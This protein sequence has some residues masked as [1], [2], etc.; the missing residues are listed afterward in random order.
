M[1]FSLLLTLFVAPQAAPSQTSAVDYFPADTLVVADFSLEPWDRLRQNTVAHPLLKELRI[2]RTFSD[3]LQLEIEGD[4]AFDDKY[5]LRKVLAESRFYLGLPAT[6]LPAG[7]LL[8]GVDALKVS[9]NGDIGVVFDRFGVQYK[10]VGTSLLAILA[11][12][13]SSKMDDEDAQLILQQYIDAAQP[14]E[15]SIPYTLSNQKSWKKLQAKAGGNNRV[16]GL[17]IPTEPWRDGHWRKLAERFAGD[18]PEFDMVMQIFGKIMTSMG[19][20]KIEGYALVT[21]VSVPFIQDRMVVLGSGPLMELYQPYSTSPEQCWQRLAQCDGASITTGVG[22]MDINGFA[23]LMMSAMSEIALDM[24][25]TD[26]FEDPEAKALIDPL[27]DLM[28]TIGPG[29]VSEGSLEHVQNTGQSQ[30]TVSVSDVEKAKKLMAALPPEILM[31]FQ[32]GMAQAGTNFSAEWGEDCFVFG[33]DPGL[34]GESTLADTAAFKQALPVM[35]DFVG[36]KEPIWLTYF[37]PAYDAF[38]LSSLGETSDFFADQ[39]DLAVLIDFSKLGTVSELEPLMHPGFAV[40]TRSSEGLEF[41]SR[42]TFGFMLPTLGIAMR[43]VMQE[44]SAMSMEFE[45]DEF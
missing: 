3:Q 32:M 29:M 22:G 18:D 45:E 40:M 41:R 30:I 42:S 24:T 9:M 36:D 31:G 28:A 6:T 20:D 5:D 4:E 16:I 10:R 19:V 26:M 12:D 7:H 27:M 2:L 14:K 44:F 11:I 1:L 34:S 37:A 8:L 15:D 43:S 17:W 38:F 33:K 21:E 39:L 35:K 13:D 23:D 25:G